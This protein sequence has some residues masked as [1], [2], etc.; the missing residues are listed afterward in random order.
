M[1]ESDD[2]WEK[3]RREIQKTNYK[4][5]REQEL[6]V[7]V[8]SLEKKIEYH[9]IINKSFFQKRVL[10]LSKIYFIAGSIISLLSPMC[11]VIVSVVPDSIVS[12]CEL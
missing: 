12:N 9:F 7:K 2:W 10:Q 4:E 11:G 5:K 8:G 1:A 6:E 3:Q